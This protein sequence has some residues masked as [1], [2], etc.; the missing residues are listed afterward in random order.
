MKQV[1]MLK[2]KG[3]SRLSDFLDSL[4]ILLSLDIS[5]QAILT[6]HTKTVSIKIELNIRKVCHVMTYSCQSILNCTSVTW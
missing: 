5:I 1:F 4:G 2:N 6:K 3:Y